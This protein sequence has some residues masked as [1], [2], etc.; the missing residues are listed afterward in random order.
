M[1]PDRVLL[2]DDEV[3]FVETLAK[4]MEMRGLYVE[5]ANTGRE[6][7]EKVAGNVF[8]AVVLDL[9]M[10]G[11]KGS[12]LL[13]EIRMRRPDVPTVLITAFGSIES[14][15]DAMRGGAYHYLAKPFRMEE[16]LAVVS[17]ALR[18]RR[19]MSPRLLLPTS[20][21]RCPVGCRASR[22]R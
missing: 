8:D 10:P 12:E 5:I 6:A 21:G 11:M 17:A 9:I 15:V 1:K 20:A 3:E 16:L 4:R 19:L 14:A 18:E 13:T 2:V 22:S 7:L